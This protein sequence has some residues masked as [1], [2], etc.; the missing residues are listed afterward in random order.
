MRKPVQ[1]SKRPVV[2]EYHVYDNNIKEVAGVAVIETNGTRTVRL[3]SSQSQYLMDQGAIGLTPYEELPEES[4]ALLKQ[5][6]HTV[7]EE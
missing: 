6:H 7:D 1:M 5:I 4:K 2:N 3:P